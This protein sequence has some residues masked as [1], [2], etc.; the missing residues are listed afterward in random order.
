[1]ETGREHKEHYMYD[2]QVWVAILAGSGD[3]S[4]L[5][6]KEAFMAVKSR[7]VA[8]QLC[9]NQFRPRLLYL[10]RNLVWAAQKVAQDDT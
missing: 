2:D 3:H 6:G 9:V 8:S 1:M 7:G 10:S 5:C 4:R